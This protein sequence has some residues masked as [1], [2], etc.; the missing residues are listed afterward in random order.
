M[1][2]F[3]M[4]NIYIFIYIFIFIMNTNYYTFSMLVYA[5]NKIK[6]DVNLLD[7]SIVIMFWLIARAHYM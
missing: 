6:C 5:I 3:Y 4:N 2:I 7:Y 1:E